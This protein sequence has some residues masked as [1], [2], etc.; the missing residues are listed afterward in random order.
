MFHLKKGKENLGSFE[1]KPNVNTLK[2]WLRT[3]HGEGLY[4]LTWKDG[5]RPCVEHITIEPDISVEIERPAPYGG[6]MVIR[7]TEPA[8]F[9]GIDPDLFNL[10]RTFGD[11][12][13][14]IKIQLQLLT[15]KIDELEIEEDEKDAA[16]G[17][18]GDLVSQLSQLSQLQGMFSGLN[19]NKPQ[20]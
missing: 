6:P 3:H 10:L 19:G 9:Q 13:S 4:K 1:K 14:Q 5:N 20:E 15:M 16:Y 18:N 7:Q 11:E 17:G 8:T 2:K 12:L